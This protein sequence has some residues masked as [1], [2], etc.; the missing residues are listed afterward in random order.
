[1]R[2]AP[3]SSSIAGSFGTS[4]TSSRA[5]EFSDR[6]RN[7]RK[8]DMAARARVSRKASRSTVQND[9][10]VEVAKGQSVV[11]LRDSRDSDH[12]K[13]ISSHNEVISGIMNRTTRLSVA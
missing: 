10:C 12:S 7:K 3:R 11:A 1:T 6:N 8:T 5:L 13:L 4:P 2:T 9:N